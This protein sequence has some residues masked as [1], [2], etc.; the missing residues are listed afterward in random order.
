MAAVLYFGP[1]F[2]RIYDPASLQGREWNRQEEAIIVFSGDSIVGGFGLPGA[3]PEILR[4]KLIEKNTAG[5]TIHNEGVNGYT[6]ADII[7]TLP[8]ILNAHRPDLV[9]LHI[10][11]NDYKN[12]RNI[13]LFADNYREIMEIFQGETAVPVVM[14]TTQVNIPLA[15]RGIRGYNDVI[16][17]LAEEYD[18]PV[19][20]IYSVFQKKSR[21]QGNESAVPECF[22]FGRRKD[23][24]WR[25]EQYQTA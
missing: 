24:S 23:C 3:F 21:R 25:K 7:R 1:F 17:D 19:L 5:I 2:S 15:N 20:D 22:N 13:E 14:T 11:W 9:F 6:T 10:G 4:D 8:S 16:K 12:N 18:T